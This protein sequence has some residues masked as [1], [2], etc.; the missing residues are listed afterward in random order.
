MSD[1]EKRFV[2][3]GRAAMVGAVRRFQMTARP[4]RM[5]MPLRAIHAG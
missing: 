4:A 3:S 5:L 1:I 2:C